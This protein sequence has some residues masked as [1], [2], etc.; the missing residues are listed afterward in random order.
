MIMMFVR[1]CM[2]T[3]SA[4]AMATAALDVMFV[5]LHDEFSMHAQCPR[6]HLAQPV[7]C[8]CEL[9]TSRWPSFVPDN[10]R[11]TCHV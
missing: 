2:F 1:Q 4:K 8:H 5:P 3:P 10:A 6:V 7:D 9:R 11:Y